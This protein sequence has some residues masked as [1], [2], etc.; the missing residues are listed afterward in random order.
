MR[1]SFLEI[2]AAGIL[3]F[4]NLSLPGRGNP[5]LAGGKQRC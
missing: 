3:I 1:T 4:A 2:I 5:P